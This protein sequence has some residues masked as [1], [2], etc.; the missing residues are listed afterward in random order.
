LGLFFVELLPAIEYS[1]SILTYYEAHL[2]TL[3]FRQNLLGPVCFL[4]FCGVEILLMKYVI[5][6][7]CDIPPLF[8]VI[9]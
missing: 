8:K 5:F 1:A 9:I 3:K 7:K 6:L 4:L 2:Y